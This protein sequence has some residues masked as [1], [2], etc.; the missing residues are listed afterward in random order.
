[1]FADARLIKNVFTHRFSVSDRK[2]FGN[3]LIYFLNSYQLR[4]IICE[5]RVHFKYFIDSC[6]IDQCIISSIK[7]AVTWITL[8]YLMLLEGWKSIFIWD[9]MMATALS[10]ASRV[11]NVFVLFSLLFTR[12]SW[13]VKIEFSWKK[14]ENVS[15]TLDWIQS[16]SKK[17]FFAWIYVKMIWDKIK[18]I[19]Q[20]LIVDHEIINYIAKTSTLIHVV[21]INAKLPI[22]INQLLIKFDIARWIFMCFFMRSF[23]DVRCA[24]SEIFSMDIIHSV[25]V[26]NFHTV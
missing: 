26:L 23:I 22:Q 5:S 20:L 17:Y 4:L 12:S 2:S 24:T 1:M 16:K 13:F 18:K 11:R 8:S 15:I 9:F 19:R 21:N 14:S 25:V 6:W 7:S 3:F 10:Y